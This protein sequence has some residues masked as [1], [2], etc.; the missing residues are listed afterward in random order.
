MAES[1]PSLSKPL[2]FVWPTITLPVQSSMDNFFVNGLVV[3]PGP[4]TLVSSFFAENDPE[5]DCSSFSQLLAGAMSLPLFRTLSVTFLRRRRCQS[6]RSPLVKG[7][8]KLQLR[9]LC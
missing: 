4:M 6:I 2:D 5:N 1:E 3:S 7:G 9:S 8:G